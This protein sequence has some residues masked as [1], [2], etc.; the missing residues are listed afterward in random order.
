MDRRRNFSFLAVNRDIIIAMY[1]HDRNPKIRK[2][3]TKR[4]SELLVLLNSQACIDILHIQCVIT[5]KFST[6]IFA[7]FIIS[8]MRHTNIQYYDIREPLKTY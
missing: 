8:L 6:L 2:K 5:V 4:V 1:R 7:N 3:T